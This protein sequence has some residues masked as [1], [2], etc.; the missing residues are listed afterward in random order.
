MKQ[1]DFIIDKK[2]TKIY[3]L[4]FKNKDTGLAEDITDWTVYYMAK[5]N[6]EDLD[7]NAV[8]TKT[9]TSFS[10]ATEGIALI[11]LEPTD[12]DIDAGNYYYE[13][14]CKD[15]DAQE[16]VLFQGKLKIKEVVIKAKG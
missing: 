3:E 9:V 14:A 15:D 11:T 1:Q 12:T 6:M 13:I 16:T 2:T 5:V 4:K 10:Q 8:I 7:A